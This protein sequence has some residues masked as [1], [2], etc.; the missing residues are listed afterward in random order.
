MATLPGRLTDA[1]EKEL[2]RQQAAI[3]A[4]L[5]RS[6]EHVALTPTHRTV[7]SPNFAEVLR[8]AGSLFASTLNAVVE[9]E[10]SKSETNVADYR[11]FL[12]DNVDSVAGRSVDIRELHLGSSVVMPYEGMTR[13]KSPTWWK[14]FIS[15]KHDNV[16]DPSQGTL[17]HALNA[18]AAP[19]WLD[20]W[21]TSGGRRR[22]VFVNVGMLYP[23]DS[24]DVRKRRF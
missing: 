7:T 6:F 11:T 2:H 24:V 5:W 3:E 13:A 23:P 16:A 9:R 10:Q 22:G 19:R 12:V 1:E 14:P 8:D 20:H 17:D 4:K 15:V 21:F 18:T